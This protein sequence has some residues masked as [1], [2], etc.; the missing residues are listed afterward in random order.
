MADE[1]KGLVAGHPPAGKA[2][3]LL[4]LLG[5]K[6]NAHVASFF[7]TVKAGGMRIVQHKT[8]NSERPAKDPVEVIGLSVSGAASSVWGEGTVSVGWETGFVQTINSNAPSL[9]SAEPSAQREH[10]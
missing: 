7:S 2:L 9:P 1:D 3:H 6:T 4:P 5:G 8:P 10:G